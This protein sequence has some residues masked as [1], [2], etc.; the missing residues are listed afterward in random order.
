MCPSTERNLQLD[1]A[2]AK[3]SSRMRCAL[4]AAFAAGAIPK[5]LEEHNR[6]LIGGD[7][8][9]GSNSLE[10]FVARPFRR[11]TPYTTSNPRLYLCSSSTPPG[12]SVHGTCGYWL[13]GRRYD[14][15]SNNDVPEQLAG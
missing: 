13:L 15:R 10:R 4:V 2:P 5:S 1:V 11:W 7:S 6:N 3:C 9:G 8:N 14:E 12:R